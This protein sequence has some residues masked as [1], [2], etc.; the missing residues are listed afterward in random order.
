GT[1]DNNPQFQLRVCDKRKK[2]PQGRPMF[3]RPCGTPRQS[4]PPG[5][6]TPGYFQNV[7]AGQTKS[8]L[9]RI[10]RP[11]YHFSH[12]PD[13]PQN[14]STNLAD[15]DVGHRMFTRIGNLLLASWF[16][17]MV[18]WPE[19]WR[20]AGSPP[21]IPHSPLTFREIVITAAICVWFLSA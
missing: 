17:L 5:V 1:L 18:I 9:D 19:N 15:L 12:E 4:T 2:V 14:P 11:E 3:S 21:P 20:W 7:P 8:A 6:E 13:R 10:L 16:L